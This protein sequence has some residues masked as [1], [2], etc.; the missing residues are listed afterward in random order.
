MNSRL[1]VQLATWVGSP[2]P[3]VLSGAVG[4]A[5]SV[6]ALK[7]APCCS[8]GTGRAGGKD[9]QLASSSAASAA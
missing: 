7:G 9:A 6:G 2:A 5:Y 1:L 8:V 4:D 3:P